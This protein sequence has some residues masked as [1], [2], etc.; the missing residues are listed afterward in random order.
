MPNSNQQR[1]NRGEKC[2]S[3]SPPPIA[4]P[5]SKNT[6]DEGRKRHFYFSLTRLNTI[7]DKASYALRKQT[8]KPV[9]SLV[10]FAMG[11]RQFSL[12]GF[13]KETGGILFFSCYIKRL[14][15]LHLKTGSTT[16]RFFCCDLH[17]GNYVMNFKC[18]PSNILGRN[19]K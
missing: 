11:F 18:T 16:D 7:S 10:K 19:L 3:A 13:R 15:V 6:D 8:V 17:Y 14:D 9:M 12:R 1:V 2:T 5:L 4:K